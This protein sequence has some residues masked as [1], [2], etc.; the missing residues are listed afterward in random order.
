M[1]NHGVLYMKDLKTG[2]YKELTRIDN[3][4]TIS[5]DDIVDERQLRRLRCHD[6]M[7]FTFT[8]P[9]VIDVNA[10]EVEDE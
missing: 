4:E 7:S 6:E 5:D 9:K 1:S 10:R 3:I 8:L 2:E